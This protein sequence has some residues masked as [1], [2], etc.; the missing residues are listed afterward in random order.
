MSEKKKRRTIP[1]PP[2][3]TLWVRDDGSEWAALVQWEYGGGVFVRGASEADARE[4]ARQHIQK[5]EELAIGRVRAKAAR[6]EGWIK[7]RM[8]T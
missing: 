6:I 8:T 4:K 5:A 1:D 7:A 2:L 3:V